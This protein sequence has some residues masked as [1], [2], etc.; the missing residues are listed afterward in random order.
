MPC[1]KLY[2]FYANDFLTFQIDLSEAMNEE[3]YEAEP[4]ENEGVETFDDLNDEL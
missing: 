1:F 2:G 4:F 3:G